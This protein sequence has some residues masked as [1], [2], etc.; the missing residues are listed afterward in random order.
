MANH[1]NLQSKYACLINELDEV[2]SISTK[3]VMMDFYNPS[4]EKN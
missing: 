1:S 2:K 3:Q 4:I